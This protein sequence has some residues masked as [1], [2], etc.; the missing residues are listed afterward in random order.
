MVTEPVEPLPTSWVFDLSEV[1]DGEDMVA[2]GGDLRAGTLVEAYRSGLFPMGLGE[3]GARPIAWWS[4]DPRG[5]LLPG[6]VHASRSLRKSL[7]RFEMRVDTAFREVVDA[8]AD[9]G[10]DGRW[11]TDE[12]ADAY[13]EL[14]ALGWA[15]SIETW[16]DGELVGG[17]YG[18][19]VGGLFAGES[20]FHRV[21]DASKAAVV[22][23]AGYVFA[24]GDPRRLI[25]VQWA[26]DHL[27]SLGVVTVSRRDYLARLE[28]AVPLA[29]P[30]FAVES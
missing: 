16:L 10:R 22:A 13:T 6:G 30:T 12:I 4:P 18:V 11:I 19:N 8:C 14:H 24:D 27:R 20:M 23:T 17:L 9:P 15:H 7:R 25:D 21:T 3:L 26:T 2:V 1:D 29:P 5:V 28:A